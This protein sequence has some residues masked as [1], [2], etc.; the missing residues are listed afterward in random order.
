MSDTFVDFK[1][2]KARV[3]IESVLGGLA[4]DDYALQPRVTPPMIIPPIAPLMRI[5]A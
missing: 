2:V 1:I 5:G 4:G 3:S